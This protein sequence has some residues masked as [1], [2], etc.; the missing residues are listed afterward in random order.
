M[1]STRLLALRE[2]MTLIRLEVDRGVE[3]PER[4]LVTEHDPG[5]AMRQ[6]SIYVVDV[7][8]DVDSPYLAGGT[9]Q[10][11]E[12][13]FAVAVV[14][15]VSIPGGKGSKVLDRVDELYRAVR[16]VV[17][18]VE[19]GSTLDE[20][21]DDDGLGVISDTRLGSTTGPLAGPTDDGFLGLYKL[22]VLVTTD[23]VTA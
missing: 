2:L 16:R 15:R 3:Y 12:D 6:E 20:L 22:D 7:D 18:D 8:G 1:T 4:V 21:A 17:L 14:C 9:D 23:E 13:E 5:D 19:Y 11:T 10:A